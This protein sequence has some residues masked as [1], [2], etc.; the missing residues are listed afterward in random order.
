MYI[1]GVK[2]NILK[3]LGINL[4]LCF[5]LLAFLDIMVNISH[6]KITHEL[7]PGFMP[8]LHL[9]VLYKTMD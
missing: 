9:Q 1:I 2:F 3:D 8:K 6:K 5:Y 4:I 7:G